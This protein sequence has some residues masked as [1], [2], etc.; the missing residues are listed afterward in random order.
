MSRNRS[1]E[2]NGDDGKKIIS[3]E[4]NGKQVS[5]AV[6]IDAL[7]IDVLRYRLGATGTKKGCGIGQC[8]TC[9]VL[10]NGNPIYSCLTLAVTVDGSRI[11]TIEGL[12][13]EDGTLNPIQEAFI[14]TG[15]IQCGFC[16]PGMILMVKALLDENPQATREDVITAISGNLCRC[17]G[18]AKIIDAALVAAQ[19][20]LG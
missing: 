14:E 16:T 9:T 18:Y 19:K 20:I 4:L 7:L 3:F 10:L 8:G 12:T 5:L 13:H 2:E 1:P 6:P 15:A 11:T 17:T